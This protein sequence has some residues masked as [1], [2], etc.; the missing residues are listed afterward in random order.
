MI[1]W[2]VK[3]SRHG[4][5]I[6]LARDFERAVAAFYK[7]HQDYLRKTKQSADPFRDEVR[8]VEKLGEVANP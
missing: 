6:V 7:F 5:T 8:A 1:A 3:T 4:E 2:R